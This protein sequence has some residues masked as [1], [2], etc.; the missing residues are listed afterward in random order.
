MKLHYYLILLLALVGF[1]SA[2][3]AGSTTHSTPAVQG[4]DV[5]S[6]QAEKRPVRG[7]GHFTAT[8]D[9]ATYLF[10]SQQNLDHL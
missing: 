2:V 8:H 4:Y 1:T 10:S 3:Q 7:N 9:G 5:V 6:Y